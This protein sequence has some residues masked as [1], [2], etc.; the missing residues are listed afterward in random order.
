MTSRNFSSKGLLCDSLRR[1]LWGFV[2]GGVGFFLSLLLP[3]LMTM[4]RALENRTQNLKEFPELVDYDWQRA[5][6]QVAALLGGGNF[7]VKTALVVMAIVC[8]VVMFAYLHSRQKVDF[9]HSLPIS[10]TR[11]F[12]NNFLTGILLTLLPYL[13]MLVIAVACAFGMGFGA[14]FDG[15]AVISALVSQMILF[16]TIYA[17]SV[18]TTVICGNTVISL[19]LLAWVHLSPM[20]ARILFIG[21]CEKFYSTYA[22]GN[23]QMQFALRLSPVVELFE[24]N[25]FSYLSGGVTSVMTGKESPGSAVGLLLAYLAVAVAAT[26]L[27]LWLFRIRR[28]E[29]AGVAMAFS[30]VKL[31]LKVYMCLFMG[32]AFGMVFGV[33]AGDF[34]FW[35]GLVIGTVLTHWIVEIVYAFDFHAIFGKPLHLVVILAVLFAG[36]LCMKFDV[37][38]YDTWLPARNDIQ[39]ISVD[40]D[41]SE[42]LSEKANIDAAYQLGKIGVQ[43]NQDALREQGEYRSI[44]LRFQ[45]SGRTA[46]RNFLLPDDEEVNTLLEQIYGSEEY[47]RVAWSLFQVDLEAG[48]QNDIFMDI[49][50]NDSASYAIAATISYPNAVEQIITTLREES[51]VRQQNSLP[52][53]RLEMTQMTEDGRSYYKG[54]VYVT[55]EDKKTLALIEEITGVKPATLSNENVDLINLRY[56]YR[57]GDSNNY[58]SET[59]Q[60]TDPADI[61]ALL[62]NACNRDAMSM[63]GTRNTIQNGFAVDS[64]T[65]SMDID[66]RISQKGSEEWCRLIY[67]KGDWPEEIIEKYRPEGDAVENITVASEASGAVS[68]GM[69]G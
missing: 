45:L 21:L 67:A 27:A 61:A 9:Y 25:G 33:I 15:A 26:A 41:V 24:I 57:Y 58:Y 12:V 13:V 30:R 51:L 42:M 37:T 8:G 28:S 1:N 54:D 16:L 50:T 7:F 31:P 69:V 44:S 60:V 40:G 38:G 66:A 5:L 20:L 68:T 4:Q 46:Y 62:Q 22:M 29:R 18:L 49:Y 43:V 65:D 32:V 59:V 56:S 17:L 19:L 36:M 2:L 11:L 23:E 10:R 53:L 39:A 34:W 3:L 52:V 6:E 35:V 55:A 14:A 47:K 63:G 64:H 48:E